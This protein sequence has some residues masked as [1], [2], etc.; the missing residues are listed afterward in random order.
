[1]FTYLCIYLFVCS[2]IY[3]F[4]YLFIHLFIYLFNNLL[5]VLCFILSLGDDDS[6]NADHP[7][8]KFF[9]SIVHE[10]SHEE[11][12]RLLLFVTG[13]NNFQFHA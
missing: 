1:M 12:Q 11:K 8:I 4:I 6:W 7:T 5:L 10:M 2:F 9:W 3:L 13:A